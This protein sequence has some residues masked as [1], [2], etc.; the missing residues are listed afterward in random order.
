MDSSPLGSSIHGHFHGVRFH[1]VSMEWVWFPSPGN[2]LGPGLKLVSPALT[3]GFFS[4]EPPGKPPRRIFI[5]AVQLLCCVWLCVTTWT[6]AHQ[7]PLSVGIARHE[8]WSGLPFPS[9]EDFPK[10]GI[11]PVSPSLAGQFFTTKPT[12]MP[13]RTYIK[14]FFF[15]PILYFPSFLKKYWS[16]EHLLSF[17]VFVF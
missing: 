1:G 15:L 10:S 17:C 16:V 12:G 9:L 3:G 11:E 8:Y 6:V 2:L 14:N 4:T 7:P 5:A 13:R